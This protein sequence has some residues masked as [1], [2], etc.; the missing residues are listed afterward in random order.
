MK[1]RS[2]IS[3]VTL[4][5]TGWLSVGTVAAQTAISQLGGSVSGGAAPAQSIQ[6]G[7]DN[8]HKNYGAPGQQRNA[9]MGNGGNNPTGA[10]GANAQQQLGVQIG[11]MAGNILG[12][13]FAQPQGGIATDSTQR[14]LQIQA[15]QLNNAGVQN[16]KW[17][18]YDAAIEQFQ[19]ALLKTPGDQTIIDN[20]NRAMNHQKVGQTKNALADVLPPAP[21]NQDSGGYSGDSGA[22]QPAPNPNLSD[23]NRVLQDGNTFDGRGTAMTGGSS[24]SFNNIP[25]PTAQQTAQDIDKELGLGGSQPTDG[26]SGNAANVATV[27]GANNG[28]PAPD[29]NSGGPNQT[30]GQAGGQ[31][32]DNSGGSSGAG[33]TVVQLGGVPPD[34]AGLTPATTGGLTGSGSD[35]KA[36]DQLMSAAAAGQNSGGNF[37][38]GG[39]YAGSLNTPG[40]S[41]GGATQSSADFQKQTQLD[42]NGSGRDAVAAKP[43]EWNKDWSD[44]LSKAILTNM[45]WL[46]RA[47]DIK[48]FAPNYWKLSQRQRLEVWMTFFEVLAQHESKFDPYAKKVE[49]DG[50]LSLGLFQIGYNAA[51]E[52]TWYTK[53]A[54]KHGV[55]L[56]NLMDEEHNGLYNPKINIQCAIIMF[57]TLT[58]KYGMIAGGPNYSFGADSYWHPLR[59]E[60]DAGDIAQIKNTVTQ[61]AL[62]M[63]ADE[64]DVK[65]SADTINSSPQ[66]PQ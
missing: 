19:K 38:S 24:P 28:A 8:L 13:M 27:T 35:T 33:Q 18:K 12:N 15:Q 61:K 48:E 53:Y 11:T 66:P 39:K 9:V 49:K 51:G 64:F 22:N 25:T 29:A 26:S 10:G 2:L 36:G 57:A 6:D 45:Y 5:A 37:D 56:S 46:E 3:I 63:S 7:F 60:G 20:L 54:S 31:T 41:A 65:N 44:T 55:S 50:N 59:L 47:K 4:A 58:Q 42:L 16:M 23:V 14:Q 21:E 30:A 34:K 62:T 32:G 40:G 52:T 43:S 17:G 1:I